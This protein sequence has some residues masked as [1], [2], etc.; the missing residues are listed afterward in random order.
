MW[1]RVRRAVALGRREEE[2]RRGA[3]WLGWPAG[4][5]QEEWAHWPIGARKM[6]FHLEMNFKIDII[7]WKFI[8]V[9]E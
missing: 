1:Q 7:V 6:L 4:P 9:A 2:E 8:L 5:T 3:A